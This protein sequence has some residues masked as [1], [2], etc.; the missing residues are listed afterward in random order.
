[1]C[2]VLEVPLLLQLRCQSTDLHFSLHD[3]LQ[4]TLDL[5]QRCLMIELPLE[6]AVLTNL[7]AAED[8][9]DHDGSPVKYLLRI[10]FR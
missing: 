5:Q 3:C 8:I 7:A 10:R 2:R 4:V 9:F 1:M 6:Q